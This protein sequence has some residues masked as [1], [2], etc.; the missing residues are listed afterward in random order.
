[1]GET[2]A[3]VGLGTELFT[4]HCILSYPRVTFILYNMKV[5]RIHIYEGTAS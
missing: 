3:P 5:M 4:R 1:M 2:T